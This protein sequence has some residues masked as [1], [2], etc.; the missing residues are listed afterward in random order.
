MSLDSE[1]LLSMLQAIS[2][3][4][5]GTAFQGELVNQKSVS[6]HHLAE[7]VICVGGVAPATRSWL[8]ARP[9]ESRKVNIDMEDRQSAELIRHGIC[10]VGAR[11]KFL[12]P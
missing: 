3:S 2:S 9:L 12:G 4:V 8:Q 1:S 10:K 11:K 5:M 7:S 6:G